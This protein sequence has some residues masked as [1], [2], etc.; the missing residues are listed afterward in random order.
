MAEMGSLVGS[1]PPGV[2]S[3]RVGRTGA[4]RGANGDNGHH[5][6]LSRRV[7]RRSSLP[8]GRALV[9]GLL[10]AM[11]AVGLYSAYTSAGSGPTSSYAVAARAL[12]AGAR[13][14]AADLATA[15]AELPESVEG[16]AFAD[17][18]VLVGATLISPLA[19]GE[20]VQ[21]SAVVAKPSDPT[22]REV[23]F[24]LP[25]DTLPPLLEH[26][27]RVDVVATYGSGNEALTVPVVRNVLLVGLDAARGRLGDDSTVVL[28]VAVEDGGDSLALAH[29]IALGKLTVVRATGA[30]VLPAD[31]TYRQ[32]GPASAGAPASTGAPAADSP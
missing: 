6:R 10:V 27:E 19:P 4:R 15:P 20:L 32:P 8:G 13:L 17:P 9:G 12:P 25:R 23:T 29:A 11:S 24:A 5:G 16:R 2:G 21:A 22:S 30:P 28:T 26:G 18:G 31:A 14:T 3:E 1:E 7:G